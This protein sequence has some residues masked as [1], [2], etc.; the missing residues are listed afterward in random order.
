MSVSAGGFGGPTDRTVDDSNDARTPTAHP[1]GPDDASSTSSEKIRQP[2]D[3]ITNR[4][5]LSVHSVG[6]DAMAEA[7]LQVHSVGEAPGS[8]RPVDEPPISTDRFHLRSVSFRAWAAAAMST[9]V[10]VVST[11]HDGISVV[12]ALGVVA[13]I[14]AA[15]VDVVE[16]RLP[17]R[18]A[19]LAAFT[20]AMS[21]AV[22]AA[23]N[24]PTDLGGVAVGAGTMAVPLFVMHLVSPSSMGFGD[25]KLAVVL[26]AALGAAGGQLGLVALCLACAGTATVGLARRRRHLPFGPGLVGGAALALALAP[27][28]GGGS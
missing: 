4:P 8:P 11:T 15:L 7:S 24:H 2:L 28:V 25:V 13:C 1:P 18:L 10:A 19:A 16:R 23:L 3:T 26:G 21:I 22:A 6:G 27:W 5:L 17:N 14:P 9:I 20:V 12:A